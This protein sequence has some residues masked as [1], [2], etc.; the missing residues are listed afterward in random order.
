M[1]RLEGRV[2]LVTGATSGIGLATAKRLREEGAQVAVAG[3]NRARLEEAAK[4]LGPDFVCIS[5]DVAKV[6]E[7]EGMFL[8]VA[9]KLGK[10]DVLFINAGIARVAPIETMTEDVYDEVFAT[11]TKG[12]FF[13]LQKAIP[14]MNDGGSIILNAIAPVVPSWR[15]QGT[16]VYTASKVALRVF[17]SAAAVELAERRIRVN[18]VSPGPTLTS[19]YSKAGLPADAASE[20]RAAI[21]SAIPLRRF[22]DPSEVASVVAFLAS[23]DASFVTGEEIVV[24]GGLA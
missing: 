23:S 24:D 17:A 21:A 22:A 6:R 9:E 13:T 14:F 19:I 5:G 3:R 16:S 8:A 1:K 10:L 18:A 15:R 7:I 12:A 4:V 11:N 20:R 2:A